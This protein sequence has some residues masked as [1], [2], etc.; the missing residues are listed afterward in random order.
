MRNCLT[1]KLLYKTRTFNFLVFIGK[2][3]LLS[4]LSFGQT[5]LSRL[6]DGTEIVWVNHFVSTHFLSPW[7]LEYIDLSTENI[8]GDMPNR[9][10]A[11]IRPIDSYVLGDVDMGY[12]TLFG[13][14]Y[15]EQYRLVYTS[16]PDLATKRVQLKHT[17]L[18]GLGKSIF[19]LSKVQAIEL[20][21]K[22]WKNKRSHYGVGSKRSLL[23]IQLNNLYVF[24]GYLFVDFQIKNMTEIP[25][26]IQRIDYS[27]EDKK[28]ARS[29][30]QQSI[31]IV[32]YLELLQD[33]FFTKT[34]RNI[35]V[36]E[37]FTLLDSK[38][39]IIRVIE[40]GITGRT[41]KL[42]INSRDILSADVP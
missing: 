22:V 34:Y 37:Q 20:A 21:K 16:N 41:I 14:G 12:I 2:L 9:Y 23:E 13:E 28:G 15:F 29:E 40:E 24:G 26:K 35:M 8:Q 39:F 7:S 18:N 30:N 38:V 19:T 10:M 11:R 32:P 33:D 36:F 4:N 3:L 27:I 6:R 31:D 42:I 17:R 5:D 1:I 25:V